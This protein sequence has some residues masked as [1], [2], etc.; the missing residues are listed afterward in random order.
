MA[1]LTKRI[2]DLTKGKSKK[3]KNEKGKSDKGLIAESFDWDEESVSSKDE[4][5]TKIKAFMVIVDDGP[6]I[7][8]VDARS[9][10]IFTKADESSSMSIPE[11]TSESECETR[12]PLPP[13]PK[14]IGAKPAGTS[15]TLISLADLTLNMADLTLNTSV[16]KK[17][18]PT[19]DK[20]SPTHAIKKKTKT[21]SLT[22]PALNSEKKSQASTK[23]HLQ[24]LIEE[25]KSLKEHIK[26]PLDNSPYVSQTG[27]SKSSKAKKASMIPKPF[28]DCKH[29]GF[30]NHHS[31]NYE[32]YPRCEICGSISHEPADCPKKQLNS[33]IPKIANKRSTKPVVK[34]DSTPTSLVGFSILVMNDDIDEL[35]CGPSGL[36]R[37]RV[38]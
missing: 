14:L 1:V 25:V 17:T 35:S 13:L 27:S 34:M 6:S 23:N 10:V 4:R 21:K 36:T 31:Y 20:M 28:K 29:N 7:G 11:I 9:E 26:V 24:T 2:D 22:V 5:T 3:G 38:T 37:V 16:P 30:N 32:Y 18:K 8:K 19:S 15:N 33:R 12:E